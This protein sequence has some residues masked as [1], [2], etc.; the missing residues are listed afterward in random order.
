MIQSEEQLQATFWKWAWNTH[1]IARRCM[2]AVPNSAIGIIVSRKDIIQAEKMKATG[3]LKGVWDLHLFWKGRF[4]I[5][6]TK[7]GSNGL[8]DDQKEWGD[9]MASHGAVRHIYRTLEEGVKIFESIIL[10]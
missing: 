6:E 2:W 10:S 1:H 5:I 3:L 7:F 9:L 4:Y 8:S